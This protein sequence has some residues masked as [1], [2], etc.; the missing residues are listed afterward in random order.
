MV[1]YSASSHTTNYFEILSEILN[2]EG[3]LSCCI[4]S[5]VTAIFLN[6]LI[7]PNGGVTSGR[8]CPAAC[9]AGIFYKHFC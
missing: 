4:G 9:T 1:K 6:R 2:L 8:V 7:L 3:H 5:K